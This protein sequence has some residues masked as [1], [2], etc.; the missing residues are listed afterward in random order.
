MRLVLAA[1]LVACSPLDDAKSIG[2]DIAELGPCDAYAAIVGGGCSEVYW[3]DLG[4][5]YYRASPAVMHTTTPELCAPPDWTPD[6]L[7]AEL[8]E[9]F[10]TATCQPTPRG[11]ALGWPCIYGCEPHHKDCDAYQGCFCD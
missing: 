6:D 7:A 10:N 9:R 2:A 3:C 1:L 4:S 11:G 8:Q 5:A